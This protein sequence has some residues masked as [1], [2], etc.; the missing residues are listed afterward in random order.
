MS[1]SGNEKCTVI[2]IICDLLIIQNCSAGSFHSAAVSGGSVWVWGR[3]DHLCLRGVSHDVPT[4]RL[5]TTHLLSLIIFQPVVISDREVIETIGDVCRVECGLA[6]TFLLNDFGE[7]FVF[8][9]STSPCLGLG[10]GVS[11]FFLPVKLPALQDIVDI[12]VGVNFVMAV[13]VDGG[14]WQWGTV[15]EWDPC[16]L[17]AT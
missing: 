15:L 2:W 5:L 3:G 10:P 1:I 8:G 7:V 17:Q 16:I 4:V 6:C 14:L 9:N 13:N 12:R 11:K